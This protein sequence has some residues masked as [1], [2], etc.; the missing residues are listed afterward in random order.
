MIPAAARQVALKALS[1]DEMEQAIE[2]TA[3]ASPKHAGMTAQ[4]DR[5]PGLRAKSLYLLRDTLKVVGT[6][7]VGLAQATLGVFLANARYLMAGGT[8]RTIRVCQ[9]QGDWIA[10]LGAL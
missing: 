4:R 8:G 10:W 9:L 7:Q 5:I 2:L 3:Q 1:A 6:Q